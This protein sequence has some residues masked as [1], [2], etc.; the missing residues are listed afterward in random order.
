MPKLGARSEK[1]AI[2]GQDANFWHPTPSCGNGHSTPSLVPRS[3]AQLIRAHEPPS[4]EE[5]HVR[6][7]MLHTVCKYGSA[8]RRVGTLLTKGSRAGS[9]SPSNRC[10][11]GSGTSHRTRNRF[12]VKSRQSR[13]GGGGGGMQKSG[14][15]GWHCDRGGGR[16]GGGVRLDEAGAWAQ[17]E[18][19][20]VEERQIGRAHV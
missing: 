9:R 8:R 19:A 4:A 18:A 17:P 16:A 7:V 20:R 13:S 11:S 10:G 6:G 14:Y 15:D 2:C 3:L 1:S 12:C 5:M